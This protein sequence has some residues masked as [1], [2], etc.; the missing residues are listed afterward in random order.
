MEQ[1]PKMAKLVVRNPNFGC[2]TKA[3]SGT[4]EKALSMDP[5]N[6]QYVRGK[7]RY[8]NLP[9]GYSDTKWIKVRHFR[10]WK[11]R[12]R[13]KR[14]WMPHWMSFREW[15]WLHGIEDWWW[16]KA[17]GQASDRIRNV[18]GPRNPYGDKNETHQKTEECLSDSVRGH[19]ILSGPA[20][21]R[22]CSGNIQGEGE[23]DKVHYGAHRAGRPHPQ[24]IRR[25]SGRMV[26][27]G[28]I[29]PYG[30]LRRRREGDTCRC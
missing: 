9:D 4:R 25:L 5:E 17:G 8:P 10:C 3:F 15:N 21:S 14:Q 20:R 30:D 6:R 28:R 13:K 2:G 12:V 24:E 1:R 11:D 22:V 29:L 19:E 16:S 27:T 26:Y 18:P 7:R 23:R